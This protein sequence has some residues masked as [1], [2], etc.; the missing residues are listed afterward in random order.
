MATIGNNQLDSRFLVF[1]PFSTALPPQRYSTAQI[2]NSQNGLFF[3]YQYPA[4]PIEPNSLSIMTGS[5]NHYTLLSPSAD[6]IWGAL[7]KSFPIRF[8]KLPVSM[9]NPEDQL[10][11]DLLEGILFTYSILGWLKIRKTSESK[12][13]NI[14]EQAK[15]FWDDLALRC[16]GTYLSTPVIRK[17]PTKE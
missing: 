7:H 1:T 6:E 10:I 5:D 14:P 9:E 3:D 2:Y 8:Q 13:V 12:I 15:A 4:S 11:F 16:E 17:Q